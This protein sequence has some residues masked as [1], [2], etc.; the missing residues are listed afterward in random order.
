MIFAFLLTHVLDEIAGYVLP[1]RM[2]ILEH[3]GHILAVA[4]VQVTGFTNRVYSDGLMKN[5]L[6]THL[7]LCIALNATPNT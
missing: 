2:M 3:S 6:E 7:L 5:K 1:L 4:V